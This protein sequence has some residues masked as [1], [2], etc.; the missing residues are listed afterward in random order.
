MTTAT[1]IELESQKEGNRIVSY[2]VFCLLEDADIGSGSRRVRFTLD[3]VFVGGLPNSAAAKNA[4]IGAKIKTMIKEQHVKWQA[5]DAA[6]NA[7][8]PPI[9]GQALVTKLGFDTM[10]DEDFAE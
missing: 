8:V 1:N 9:I 2:S 6:N 10:E 3:E 7:K 5:Q 4:A